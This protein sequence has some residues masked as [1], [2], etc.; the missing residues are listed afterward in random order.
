VKLSFSTIYGK[1]IYVSCNFS[2]QD[3]STQLNFFLSFYC[4]KDFPVNFY[5][6][7]FKAL[8]NT[9]ANPRTI[10]IR[11]LLPELPLMAGQLLCNF[12]AELIENFLGVI[13]SNISNGLLPISGTGL[14]T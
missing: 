5:S 9:I 8:K 6:R 7:V 11:K 1:C 13:G 2:L 12:G 10:G 14:T 4:K 3:S